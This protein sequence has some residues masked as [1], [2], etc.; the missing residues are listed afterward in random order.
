MPIN[1][2]MPK[3]GLTMTEGLIVEWKKKEGDKVQK[4]EILFVLETEKVTYEVEAPEDGVL[5][6][7]VVQEQETV[8]VGA[9]V[10]YILKPGES[11]ADLTEA[12]V[13][14]ASPAAPIPA[15][16]PADGKT[17]ITIIGGGTGG[18]PAA[19]RAARMG[20][21]V[22]LIE[23][24]LLGGV[25]LNRGCI[26]TKALLQTANVINTMKESEVFGVKCN[27]YNVDFDVVMNRKRMVSDQ[28]SGGVE[29]L[30]TLKK[31]RVI[32]GTASLVNDKAVEIKETGEKVKSDSILIATGSTPAKIP[33]EGM[34]GPD[35]LNSNDV[36][37]M[38]SL[39]K[40]VVII[41]GGVI[42]CEFARFLNTVGTDVTILELMPNII[43]EMDNEITSILH[44]ILE[45]S[46]VKIFT[47][48]NVKKVTHKKGVNTVAYGLE[49]KDCT[50]KAEKI[51]STVGRKPDLAAL[52]V[53][54]L[55]IATEK[56]AIVVNE[57]METNVPGIYAAGD[58]T[59]GIML[60]HVSTAEGECAVR[61]AMG[62]A[63]KMSHRIVPSCIYTDPEIA[64]VGLTEKQ[65]AEIADIKVGRF[66][67]SGNGKAMV[68]NKTE[69]M[70][71]VISE[72]KHGEILGVHII[73]PHATDMISEAVLGMSME[74][75]EEELAHAIHPHPT[76]SEAVMEAGQVLSGGCI[77]MP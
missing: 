63:T 37:E 49:G 28:L 5:G 10:A 6:R 48:A 22:T 76:L 3:L 54:K 50:V 53:D 57:Y 12:P 66:P 21:E 35:V 67:F 4:G 69:G 17:R 31:V 45:A 47:N 19:I 1:I 36:L 56:G 65:A 11:A 25:C 20:A 34:D 44:A 68:I 16:T 14:L 60:A 2:V 38:K 59:G 32:N 18:Y 15:K 55:G 29:K 23:K 30:L 26:P 74:M 43:P 64:S 40:S 41:G 33:I 24:D 42:S 75:T 8:P 77:H 72:K 51:I 62:E 58:I 52:N 46:G 39:P 70:V 9:L 71:K 73:G 13:A 27:G 61:N 7:I